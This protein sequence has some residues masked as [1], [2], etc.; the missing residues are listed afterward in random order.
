MA[1]QGFPKTCRLLNSKD[2]SPVFA[3]A[4]FKVSNPH[5]LVL[6]IDNHEHTPRLGIVV[7]RKSIA[8]AVQ[9]NRIKRLIREA[10]RAD[11]SRFGTIDLVVLV[12]KG[13]D[14]LESDKIRQQLDD[15]F[16]ALARKVG[17]HRRESP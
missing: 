3:N 16:S 11:R 12:R 13:P 5:F 2:Y 9:R 1:D 8:K 10:F 4:R 6:A 14:Q 15:L 7:G 17:N